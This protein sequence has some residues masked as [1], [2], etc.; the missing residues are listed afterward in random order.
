[1]ASLTP[2]LKASGSPPLISELTQLG[3]STISRYATGA[4]DVANNDANRIKR[5]GKCLGSSGPEYRTAALRDI[6]PAT[7]TPAEHRSGRGDQSARAQAAGPGRVVQ[8]DDN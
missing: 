2:D 5:I 7:A 6:I 8:C 3:C 4:A 1:M